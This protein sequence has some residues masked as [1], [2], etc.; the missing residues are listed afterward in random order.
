MADPNVKAVAERLAVDPGDLFDLIV[1]DGGTR[2]VETFLNL[3]TKESARRA[4]RV[5]SSESNLVR[6]AASLALPNNNSPGAHTGSLNDADVWTADPKSTPAK[7]APATAQA[8]DSDD[9]TRRL[10]KAASAQRPD[11]ISSKGPICSIS[12]AFSP[13]RAAA[14][15]RTTSI[16]R[17]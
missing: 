6:I 1:R 12:F 10:I 4:D 5:L 17:R 15:C 3:T 7:S 11:C 8:A 16:R 2:L 13:M 9:S 14:T